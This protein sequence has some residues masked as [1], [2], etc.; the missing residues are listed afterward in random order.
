MNYCNSKSSG[1]G[2]LWI[3]LLGCTK[4]ISSTVKNLGTI[5][6]LLLTPLTLYAAT[7]L[8]S[9]DANIESDL[10]GYRVYESTASTNRTNFVQVK[11]VGLETN[12]IMDLGAGN[13]WLALTAFS[14]TGMESAFSDIVY[15]RVPLMVQGLTL[16]FDKLANLIVLAWS[17]NPA[18]DSISN[19]TVYE[20]VSTNAVLV[21]VTSSTSTTF[22]PK[23]GRHDYFVTANSSTLGESAPSATVGYTGITKPVNFRIS[24][25]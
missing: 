1:Y 23:M 7:V 21:V 8:L 10:A 2:R 14:T 25:P 11:S 16:S 19:Y 22:A 4:K 9:W 24:K 13:H 6:I 17:S 18:I 15:Q 5:L 12:T 20:K 3:I